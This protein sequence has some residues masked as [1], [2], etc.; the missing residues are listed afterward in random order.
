MSYH[1]TGSYY[2]FTP[3]QV[4]GASG[5]GCCGAVGVGMGA[6]AGA[7]G[8]SASA[9]WADVQAT[10]AC[11]APGGPFYGKCGAVISTAGAVA[12]TAT[13]STTTN[14]AAWLSSLFG[15]GDAVSDAAC[16]A[17]NVAGGRATR[18]I[19]KALNEL[20]VATLTVDG[21]WGPATQAGWDKFLAINKLAKGPGLGITLPAL[22]VMEGQAATKTDAMKMGLGGLAVAG[23]VGLG[24]LAIWALAKKKKGA[25]GAS[26]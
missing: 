26:V 16:G 13:A 5:L 12:K 19:Q 11:Y 18:A 9:V 22:Q 20:G 21:Q 8:F 25:A 23:A 1:G 3:G 17:C 14:P 7:T 10:N 4:Y 6:V 24:A 15:L 2:T